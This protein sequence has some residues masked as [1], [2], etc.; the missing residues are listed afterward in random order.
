MTL[1]GRLR[2]ALY[3][4]RRIQKQPN[5]TDLAPVPRIEERWAVEPPNPPSREEAEAFVK[6]Y[7]FWYHRIYLGNGVYT[8]PPTMADLVWS[9]IQPTLPLDLRDASM[10]DVGSNAGFFSILAKLRVQAVFWESNPSKCFLIRLNTSEI[11]GKWISNTV[12]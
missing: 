10:L 7:S 6:S 8:L 5:A 3:L 2:K 1:F 12:Y 11:S 4:Q 9:H